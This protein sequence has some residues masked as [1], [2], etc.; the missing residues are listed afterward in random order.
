[1]QKQRIHDQQTS[2]KKP[3]RTKMAKIFAAFKLLIVWG[4]RVYRLYK[5]ITD[6]PEWLVNQF[7]GG[8]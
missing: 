8:N 4:W 3:T 6:F 1:M 7:D 2:E 5:L